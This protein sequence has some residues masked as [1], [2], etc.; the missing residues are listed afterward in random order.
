[1]KHD[2]TKV[3]DC[4]E[5]MDTL[6]VFAGLFSAV[7]TAFNIESYKSLDQDP[8]VLLLT[9]ISA[10]LANMNSENS[11]SPLN[12]AGSEA[13]RSPQAVRVNSLWFA[14][15]VCSL[16]TA[17][18]AI[19]VKQWLR[20]YMAQDNTLPRA[21][22]R[23]RYWRYLGL[24]GW[25]VFEIA[26]F[27]PFLLQI[28]LLLFFLGL[29]L[30]LLALD[31]IVG[32][33]VTSM[34]IVWVA[35]FVGSTVAPVFSP[36][37]PYKTPVLQSTVQSIRDGFSSICW[38]CGS[39]RSNTSRYEDNYIRQDRTLD[40]PA[41][42]AAD[43]ALVDDNLVDTAIRNCLS[44]QDGRKVVQC[45][46]EM[47]SHRCG[48]TLEHLQQTRISDLQRTSNLFRFALADIL[49]DVLNRELDRR[50]QRKL[51]VDWLPW[52]SS[53][54]SC[55]G[56]ALL[57]TYAASQDGPHPVEHRAGDLLPRLL[58][59]NPVVARGTL[60]VLANSRFTRL[61]AS[62]TLPEIRLDSVAQNMLAGGYMCLQASSTN[63]LQLCQ[64]ILS[65]T[66]HFQDRT[67][68]RLE[69][70][71]AKFLRELA[72]QIDENMSSIPTDIVYPYDTYPADL[73]LTYCNRLERKSNYV[74]PLELLEVLT[75][76]ASEG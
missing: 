72:T 38:I 31:P 16:V 74:V 37:C 40:I 1:M 21:R 71:F 42:V 56:L 41:L 34:V 58:S 39:D 15:L 35:L 53:A 64:V 52:M 68:K 4:K 36:R 22:V 61:S 18:L 12:L 50:V 66:L 3:R 75:K 57:P 70:D 67:L 76:L 19:L 7:L 69:A 45:V 43:A 54:L 44:D 2:E 25:R 51:A 20:E 8:S 29:C 17:S 46:T 59:Q 48:R 62:F 32:W 28:A 73:C 10:Q 5:D 13:P 65:L 33:V 30:F 55:I 24:Q 27:L 60:E 26:A 63:P 49:I 23:V 6:L 11:N 47:I 14:S 9:Q